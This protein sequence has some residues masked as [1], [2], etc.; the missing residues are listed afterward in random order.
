MTQPNLLLIVADC[1][2][3]DYLTG[4]VG[5]ADT[6]FLDA[7]GQ[8]G[9]LYTDM[10]AA[11]SITT[12]NFTSILS[13]RYPVEHGLRF[14]S[15]QIPAKEDLSLIP[16][17]KAQGY[18]T[19]ALMTGPLFE[20]TGLGHGFDF[21]ECRNRGAYLDSE[22]GGRFIERLQSAHFKEPWFIILH[23]WEL[24]QPRRV[25]AESSALP[26][27]PYEKALG[28]VD[29][30]IKRIW[31]AAVKGTR[32]PLIGALTG[33]HG[34]WVETGK[35][36]ELW[37]KSQARLRKVT[38]PDKPKANWHG[39]HIYDYLTRVPLLVWGETI[40]NTAEPIQQQIRQID[41]LPTLI[42]AAMLPQPPTV[43]GRSAWPLAQGQLMSAVPA[44]L[45]ASGD[46]VLLQ[47]QKWVLGVR[48]EGWKYIYRPQMDGQEELYDLTAD[49]TEKH[50]IANQNPAKASQLR[51][52]IETN[53]IKRG[54]DDETA[55]LDLTATEERL[56]D[57][58]YF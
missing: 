19:Y 15:S 18:H 48:H 29:R 51:Q 40:A 56:R 4:E 7:M 10:I 37:R 17:F 28:G 24:H 23:L 39:Y 14:L 49:P 46:T 34:E 45:E 50:N 44:F 21:Y 57:L 33:D 12:P 41:L 53:Y 1:L 47:T 43:T 9:A 52:L 11:M 32:Q 16:H 20:E 55:E 38:M 5:R 13:G 25:T 30:Q 58:G 6:P 22:W 8:K 26:G 42:E 35:M 3:S 36:D 54:L 2:R 31:Q 27:T